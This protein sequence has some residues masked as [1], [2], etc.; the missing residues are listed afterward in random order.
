[1]PK[2]TIEL[3]TIP[4]KLID[5]TYKSLED[6]TFNVGSDFTNYLDDLASIQPG[7][8]GVEKVDEEG[9]RMTNDEK[10]QLHAAL[11]AQMPNVPDDDRRDIVDLFTGIQ[12]LARLF[13]RKGY[14]RGKKEAQ[15]D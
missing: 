12:G 14:E 1:M 3:L 4:T 9:G 5:S 13:W 6:G 8:N 10:D 2:E 7:I 11:M 15:T